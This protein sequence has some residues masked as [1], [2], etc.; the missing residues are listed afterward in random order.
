MALSSGPSRPLLSPSSQLDATTGSR[1]PPV[2]IAMMGVTG[3]G[4]SSFISLLCDTKIEIGHDL[5]SCTS[6]VGV[7]PCELFPRR[8]IYLIDTPG[9]DDSKRKDTEV[10]REL[11]SYLSKSYSQNIKLNGIM[12]FHRISDNK[13]QGSAKKNLMMFKKL[14]GDNALKNVILITSMWDR[15]AEKE[16]AKRERELTQTPEFWGFMI[17]KGSKAYRHNNSIESAKQL[18]RHFLPDIKLKIT[19]DLQ[20][21]MVDR[22]MSLDQTGAGRELENEIAKER[23]RFKIEL[24]EIREQLM[25]AMKERDKEA[26]SA[27]RE[28]QREY[29]DKLERLGKDQMELQSTLDKTYQERYNRLEIQM[30]SHQAALL[31]RV[32]Q[33]SKVEIEMIKVKHQRELDASTKALRKENDALK[34]RQQ[35]PRRRAS[36]GSD[37][38]EWYSSDSDSFSQ[39]RTFNFDFPQPSRGLSQPKWNS[40]DVGFVVQ[41]GHVGTAY[42]SAVCISESGQLAYGNA[43]TG[44]LELFDLQSGKTRVF[45]PKDDDSSRSLH[46]T[47]NGRRIVSGSTDGNVRVFSAVTGRKL[48]IELDSKISQVDKMVLS[49]NQWRLVATGL[50]NLGTSRLIMFDLSPYKPSVLPPGSMISAL[51]IPVNS[52]ISALAISANSKLL[53]GG[54]DEDRIFIWEMNRSLSEP[55]LTLQNE[56]KG[57]VIAVSFIGDTHLISFNKFSGVISTWNAAGGG[58]LENWFQ[59]RIITVTAATFSS[60]NSKLAVGTR[61]G[62]VK[63]YPTKINDTKPFHPGCVAHEHGNSSEHEEIYDLAFSPDSRF[64]ATSTIKGAVRLRRYH[65]RRG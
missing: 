31:E 22:N 37:S 32:Q 20:Q 30:E 49:P 6:E 27:M 60:H 43:K 33:N 38:S 50:D 59:I 62:S 4:K 29:E 45:R 7:Y 3:A 53:A 12:Y 48:D 11:A 18:L 21:E 61:D 14:C 44:R 10:L 23:A 46:Y 17:S 28:I 26:E 35:Q 54:S 1:E 36:P 56:R 57:D 40:L 42:T 9:F 15:V 19:L 65:D 58:L 2:Y 24:K 64:L 8:T 51:T 5:D 16:G 63:I 39:P 25:E 52:R 13:M 47:D 34:R 41:K 55:S